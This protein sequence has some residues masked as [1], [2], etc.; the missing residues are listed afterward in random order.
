MDWADVSKWRKAKRSEILA[1]RLARRMQERERVRDAVAAT[2]LRELPAAGFGDFGFYWPIRGELDFRSLAVRLAAR[3][4]RASLP[5]VVRER[6]PVEFWAW[7]VG[8]KTVPG[9]W[10]IPVPAVRDEVIP[11]LL[12]IPLVGFD[13]AGYRLGYGAGY[14]DRTLAAREDRPLAVGVGYSCDRLATIH[15]QSHDIP[16]DAIV[17]EEGIRWF[18]RRDV[19]RREEPGRVAYVG[20]AS[21]A[22]PPCSLHEADPSYMGYLSN[23]E[24][25]D[26]LN[27]LL[28]GERAGARGVNEIARETANPDVRATLSAVAKDEARYCAMLYGHIERFGGRPTRAT[29]AFLEKLHAADGHSAKITLLNKGQAWV[30][31]RLAEI[32]P[33]VVDADLHRDLREMKDTH[34]ANISR[35]RPFERSA[36]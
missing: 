6:S 27:E 4:G 22:S 20:T 31:R 21:P 25:V 28:E 36:G 1:S 7:H 18:G 13:D 29:G 9:V 30:S 5:V 12:L 2:V 16:M 23:A 33:K 35:C 15:P 17:T 24:I 26:A 10:H 14:Y 8:V 32:L 19:S 34:D 3:G 11:D